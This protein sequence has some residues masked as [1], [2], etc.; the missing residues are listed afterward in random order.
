MKDYPFWWD[1]VPDLRLQEWSTKTTL[2]RSSFDV[3]IVGAGYT[4]LAAARQLAQAGASVVVVDRGMVGEGASSRNG[5]QVLTGL[6]LD[7]ATLVR[8][9]GTIVARRLF[10]VSREALDRF[11]AL[12][13]SEAI[14]CE[15]EARGHL[16]A[17]AKRSHLDDFRREQELL[18]RVFDHDVV[19]I[20]ETDQASELGSARYHGL[21]LDERSACV[22]P[23]KYVHGLAQA[24][25]R[26]GAEIVTGRTVERIEQ[27]E[28]KW[29]LTMG[30]ERLE[31]DQVLIATNGY[32]TEIAPE[33][34]RRLVAIGSYI[35]ATEPL[36]PSIASTLIPRRRAVFD[37]KHL[38]YYFRLTRDDRLLFGGRAEFTQPTASTTRTAAGILERGMRDVF[39]ALAGVRIDYAWGG[40]VAVTRDQMPHAGTIAGMHYAAGYCGHGIAMATYL[41]ELVARRIAGDSSGHP[42]V[43]AEF[44]PFPLYN[45]TPWFLPLVGA[46]YKMKDWIE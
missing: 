45:G 44:D 10:D 9:Y 27:R 39:P 13:A 5:G 32:T 11:D 17:A 31:A 3:A 8:R 38:L 24:A 6:K 19:V 22:N 4:G 28:S 15:L 37:S 29:R 20:D 16:Q 23:A 33:L 26:W 25:R 34:R 46:Y 43:D 18:A 1:T 12:V 14:D 40:A 30:A 7:P 21:L 36:D 35:I 41:G 2:S 42:L